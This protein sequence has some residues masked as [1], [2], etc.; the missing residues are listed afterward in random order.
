M[1]YTV[2]V[3]GAKSG[4]I[5]TPSTGM[6]TIKNAPAHS[7]LITDFRFTGIS[8]L[9]AATG[10]ANGKAQYSPISVTK[11]MDA[12]SPLI[13]N[14]FAN[15]ETLSSVIVTVTTTNARKSDQPK[16]G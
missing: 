5:Y 14:S 16:L 12:G 15:H 2:S 3:R 13:L 4:D 6:S 11:A 9:N 7:A 8:P 1:V 10:Q